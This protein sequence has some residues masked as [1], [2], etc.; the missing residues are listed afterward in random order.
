MMKDLRSY[1]RFTLQMS[2][3]NFKL[4]LIKFQMATRVAGKL[5]R[6]IHTGEME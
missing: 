2:A 5:R 6:K 4:Y 1:L 3:F